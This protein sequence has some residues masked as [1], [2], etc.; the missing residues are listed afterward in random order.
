MMFNL[1]NNLTNC[2]GSLSSLHVER[3]NNQPV[4][5]IMNER[6]EGM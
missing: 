4:Y 2:L 1:L 5:S 6:N 3:S